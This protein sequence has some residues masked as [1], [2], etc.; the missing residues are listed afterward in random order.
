M[1]LYIGFQLGTFYS[2][3]YSPGCGSKRFK[4]SN[5][6]KLDKMSSQ[7]V[8]P[9]KIKTVAPMYLIMAS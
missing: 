2:Q 4:V 1:V 3:E 7:I 8:Q 5:F 6:Y 9:I